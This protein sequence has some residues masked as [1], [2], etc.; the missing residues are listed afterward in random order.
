MSGYD[1]TLTRDFDVTTYQKAE[2]E[3]FDLHAKSNKENFQ[4]MILV[5]VGSEL[6]GIELFDQ[7]GQHTSVTLS[8]IKNNPTLLPS[9]FVF[10]T[11]K[12]TDV[13]EQ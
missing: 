1:N 10:K 2:N 5:F 11:P 4:R 13:V 6:H 7:L 8:K 3:Y 9:L 12:G